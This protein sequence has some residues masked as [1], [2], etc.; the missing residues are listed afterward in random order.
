MKLELDLAAEFPVFDQCFGNSDALRVSDSYDLGFHG[1]HRNYKRTPRSTNSL[2]PVHIRLQNLRNNDRAVFLLVILDDRDPS[3][4]HGEA[5]PI[6]RVN[7]LGLRS[8]GPSKSQ[9][10]ATR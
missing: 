3:A 7:K 4:S 1:L 10:H 6:Q 8:A 5:R 9:I 2:D